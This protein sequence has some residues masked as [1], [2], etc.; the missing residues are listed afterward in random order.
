MKVSIKL[1]ISQRKSL[2]A[3]YITSLIPHDAS[4]TYIALNSHQ[5]NQASP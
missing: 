3:C 4:T 1:T 5:L 2:K